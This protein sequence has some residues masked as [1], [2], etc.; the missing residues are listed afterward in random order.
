MRSFIRIINGSSLS[1]P[2]DKIR[3]I[4]GHVGVN[5]QMNSTICS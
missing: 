4:S 3:M 5:R 1:I 2:N